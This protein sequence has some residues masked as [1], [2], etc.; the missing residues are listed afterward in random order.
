[1]SANT[2]IN[3]ASEVDFFLP[4]PERQT[5]TAVQ[6]KDGKALPKVFQPIDIKGVHYA[7]RIGVSPMCMYSGV[8]GKMTPYHLIHYGAFP[9]RGAFPIVEATLVSPE[10][11]LSPLDLGIWNDEQAESFRPVVD[12]AHAQKQLIGIQIA[13]GG[14]KS[15][16]QP[17]FIHL[18]QVCDEL[19]GGWPLKIV[20]P[21]AE[22]FRKHG[23]LPTPNE[24]TKD[25]IKRI[26]KQFGD[27]AKRAVNVGF[28]FIEI[29]G[30]HGYLI[31]EFMS[32]TSNHRSDEY[33]GSFDNRIRFLLEVIDSVRQALGDK[34]DK[35]PIWL[36]I[37]ALENSPE[38]GAWTIDDSVELA[39]LIADKID[40]LDTSLGGN[41]SVQ[42]RRSDHV[43][44]EHLPIHVPLA[45]AVKKALGD[46]L[47]VSCVGDLNDGEQ[48]N[49]FLEQGWFDF[50]LVGQQFL[51]NPGLAIDWA[52]KLG[53]QIEI[54]PQYTWGKYT[55][56]SQ[57][58]ELIQRAEAAEKAENGKA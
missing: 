38:P 7:N 34:V 12:Y 4:A 43:N 45:R 10:G 56:V 9:S 31:N 21:L 39:K 17:P 37:S 48:V 36:R 26:V 8:D 15:S 30:A 18:E 52:D 50:A 28:D 25:D 23:N 46:K 47:L 29:H 32:S 54:A 57:I 41:N 42:F 53:V 33:G 6:P 22:P 24:L 44:E 3:T 49:S 40:V 20:A 14:R 11:R 13:H 1:M 55:N 19:V 58:V 2:P 16:G 35:V 27:A 5:G 51:E